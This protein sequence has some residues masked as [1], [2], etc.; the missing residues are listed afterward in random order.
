MSSRS[1]MAAALVAGV[2]MVAALG[3]SQASA[4]ASTNHQGGGL[5]EQVQAISRQVMT[6]RCQ[7]ASV[8]GRLLA[9]ESRPTPATGPQGPKGDTGPAG[10]QGA[11][12]PTGPEGAPGAVG[13]QGEVGPAG[14]QGATGPA[15]LKG[16]TGETGPAGPAG[17]STDAGFWPVDD[18]QT[19]AGVTAYH[20]LKGN[21]WH[22]E[23]GV[24][25]YLSGPVQV[26]VDEDRTFG[27]TPLILAKISVGGQTYL[28]NGDLSLEGSVPPVAAGT[29]IAVEY[30]SE[31][32]GIRKHGTAAFSGWTYDT[33]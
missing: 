12:G 2:C 6:L 17:P 19:L 15:G 1:R 22:L 23:I 5:N 9:L 24:A 27:G 21:T 28:T 30:W 31:G 25:S 7:M 29:P 13:A 16:D 14:S 4:G 33:W 3:V 20:V 18:V 32:Y 26:G 8:L 10:S 11:T